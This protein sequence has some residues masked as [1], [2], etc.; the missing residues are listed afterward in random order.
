[1]NNSILLSSQASF[2]KQKLAHVEHIAL[3][4][5]SHMVNV[6][7]KPM[8]KMLM[9]NPIEWSLSSAPACFSRMS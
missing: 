2:Y 8:Y 4:G 1:M 7:Q 6:H 9:Q 3:F 5:S